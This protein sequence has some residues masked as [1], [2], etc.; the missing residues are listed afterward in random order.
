MQ[1]AE[2]EDME[3]FSEELEQWTWKVPEGV[4]L[5]QIDYVMMDTR[6]IFN[7]VVTIGEQIIFTCSDHHMLRSELCVDSVYEDRVKRSQKPKQKWHFNKE[8]FVQE[9]SEMDLKYKVKKDINEDYEEFILQIISA[10][11]K[12]K[13]L[14]MLGHKQRISEETESDG[15]EG[16]HEIKRKNGRRIQNIG[17]RNSC[18]DQRKL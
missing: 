14:K 6:I 4:T 16:A 9:V 12:A 13:S 1:Q 11:K 5:N 3:H 10:A 17:Q 18:E 2:D 7:D 8:A 15:E